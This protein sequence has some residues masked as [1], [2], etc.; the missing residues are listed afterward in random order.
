M[1]WEGYERFKK[2]HTQHVKLKTCKHEEI[3]L[4]DEIGNDVDEFTCIELDLLTMSNL[5]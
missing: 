5:M 2:L 4:Q 3:N 1:V